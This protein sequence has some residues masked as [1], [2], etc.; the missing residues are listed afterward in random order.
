MF[1]WI[2]RISVV[3]DPKLFTVI[4]TTSIMALSLLSSMR[5]TL[6]Q[7]CPVTIEPMPGYSS[8][9]E[10]LRERIK[11]P[12]AVHRYEELVPNASDAW[13]TESVIDTFLHQMKPVSAWGRQLDAMM[14]VAPLKTRRK[15]VQFLCNTPECWTLWRDAVYAFVREFNWLQRMVFAAPPGSIE[16]VGLK[17][18]YAVRP[19]CRDALPDVDRVTNIP[20]DTIH[21]RYMTTGSP[22]KGFPNAVFRS[23]VDLGLLRFFDGNTQP[24]TRHE[25][26]LYEGAARYK[27]IFKK[28]DEYHALSFWDQVRVHLKTLHPTCARGEDP[29]ADCVRKKQLRE[30][31]TRAERHLHHCITLRPKL[32]FDLADQ[33]ASYI[34]LQA[35]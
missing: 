12:D 22:S 18:P 35:H 32:P 13:D 9:M 33:V 26:L 5:D 25:V 20:W 19:S 7:W 31:L 28:L 4:S 14:R 27:R 1:T 10:W 15:I 29:C 23:W 34:P 21:I 17:R 3:H 16:P 24:M 11:N 6:V 2:V 8:R 30:T